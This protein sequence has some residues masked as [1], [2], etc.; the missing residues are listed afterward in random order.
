MKL[1]Q[2]LEINDATDYEC[3]KMEVY[4]ANNRMGPEGLCPTLLVFG[5]LLCP[6]R[7]EPSPFQSSGQLEIEVAKGEVKI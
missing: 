5:S 4:A 7:K 1:R 2:A 3:L 6:A